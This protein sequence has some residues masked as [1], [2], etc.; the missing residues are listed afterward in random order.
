M[1]IAIITNNGKT[2]GRHFGR[3]LHYA[4]VT[5]EN[6]E[7]IARET[8]EKV[9]HQDFSR[10]RAG[11]S[12]HEHGHGSGHHHGFGAG[13]QSRHARMIA[14]I[15]DCEVVL[16]RGMGAGMYRNLQQAG[17][18]PILTIVADIDEAVT[19]YLEGHLEDHPE[20]LH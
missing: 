1:K 17:I 9:G 16:A 15:A 11:K 14:S 19:T 13:A 6:G 8:R 5:V 12:E 4:V 20:R 2:I 10:D 18:R 7:V 3:A